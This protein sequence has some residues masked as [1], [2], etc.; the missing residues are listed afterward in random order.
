MALADAN[1]L[2]ALSMRRLA[3]D[4]G[5]ETMSLYHYFPSKVEL[6]GAML[7]AVYSEFEL[8]SADGDWRS[9]MRRSAISAHQA[10]L[11]HPWA[12]ALIGLPTSASRAQLEWMNPL[13]RG[14]RAAGF[15]AEMTHHA[16]HAIESH[17]V[18]YTLWVLPFMAVARERPD[19]VQRFIEHV[20]KSDLP[21]LMEHVEYHMADAREDDTPEF[22]F[23]LDV[24]L[25]GLDRLRDSPQA[26]PA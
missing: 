4:L 16:Y 9:A 23:G 6:L 10:L 8:P 12:S 3:R 25:D 13:L 21:H 17:I 26:S 22:E 7:G 20:S 5:V 1:G 19:V 24:L 15:S 11:Q 14:L 2:D 18:G